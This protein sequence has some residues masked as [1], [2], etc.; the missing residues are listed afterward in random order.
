MNVTSIEGAATTCIVSNTRLRDYRC[1]LAP[2]ALE[3]DRVALGNETAA[4]LHVSQGDPVRVLE[5]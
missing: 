1:C 3:G 5:L 4:A 2:V